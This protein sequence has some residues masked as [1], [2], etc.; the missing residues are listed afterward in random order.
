MK[1][2]HLLILA[3]FLLCVL[4]GYWLAGTAAPKAQPQAGK[5][6]PVGQPRS[7][8][9]AADEPLPKFRRGERPPQQVGDREA[10]LL[11]AL[12]GQRVLM[13]ADREAMERFL[14]KLSSGVQLLGRIDTLHALR[15]GF[16]DPLD[17]AAL[18]DGS[19]EL[20][21]IFP[22][23]TPPLPEGSV[24]AGAMPLGGAL[25]EWL[26]I[27][28]DNSE[29]GRGVR[30]AVL[31]TGV[32]D[33]SAF[34]GKITAIDL[35][36]P[37]ADS[38]ARNGHGTAVASMV[39][40]GDPLTP[41]VAPAADL[42]AVRVADDSGRSDSFLIAQ[43]IMA[44]VDA[45]AQLINI[46]LAGAGDSA[47]LTQAVAYAKERGALVFAATGNNG[48]DQVLYPAGTRGVIAVGAVDAAGNPLDFSNQGDE[49]AVAAPGYGIQAA[50]PGDQAVMVSGTSFSTPIVVAAVAAVMTE[51]GNIRLT[52]AQAWN[53]LQTYLN[54]GGAAGKD[55]QL[56][57]GMPD[58]GRVLAA[59]TPG[60]RDAA[61]A[62]QRILPPDSA[63]PNGQVEVLV[64]NRG[65]ESL[66][67]TGVKIVADGIT[68]R[69]NITM[70]SP[71]AVATVRVPVL[72]TPASGG[73]ALKVQSEVSLSAGQTDAKPSNDRRNE[74][75]APAAA[76]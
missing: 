5:Q 31:D 28:S 39:I 63:N 61:L 8:V 46:S 1:L 40:G 42:L 56:G 23:Y 19:E 32:A 58:L 13:F 9:S 69:H 66:L 14:A 37:S 33:H 29:W 68:S 57:A 2:R 15:V 53:L 24:Q 51:A 67:N 48:I 71:N 41:G 74:S 21:F 55:P 45:G 16:D 17:L 59:G 54:D 62:S 27:T 34:H 7:S 20:S 60:I 43:G 22:V 6:P 38:A 10:E 25:H 4:C 73:A 49:V 70:L 35:L 36:P 3:G 75:Y 52:P 18:L 11:G 50:W 47:L 64:Q 30:I 65:T 44:A 26:G 12:S 72:R 76:P